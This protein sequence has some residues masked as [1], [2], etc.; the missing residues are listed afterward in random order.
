MQRR[1]EGRDDGRDE[2]PKVL[3]L[4]GFRR[5]KGRDEPV[6]EKNYFL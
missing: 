1:D 5:D 2:K 6:F 3:Y 4:L